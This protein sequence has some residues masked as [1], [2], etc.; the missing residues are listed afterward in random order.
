MRRDSR[1]RAMVACPF[2]MLGPK[3]RMAEGSLDALSVARQVSAGRLMSRG[4]TG[5]PRKHKACRVSA[6]MR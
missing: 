4:V 3:V 6:G 1:Q 5:N 2:A